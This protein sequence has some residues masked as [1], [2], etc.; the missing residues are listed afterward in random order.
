MTENQI[1]NFEL[2]LFEIYQKMSRQNRN[3]APLKLFEID[4][5]YKVIDT[6]KNQK[7]FAENSLI[8]KLGISF[9]GVITFL[10]KKF[11]KNVT[12]REEE[13]VYRLAE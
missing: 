4:N 10:G 7:F 3:K 11:Y 5:T 13:D 2:C 12:G 1:H 8:I 6:Q 9:L